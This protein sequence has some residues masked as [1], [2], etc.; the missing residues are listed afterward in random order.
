MFAKRLFAVLLAL[1]I[2]VATAVTVTT[3]TI[4]PTQ[5]GASSCGNASGP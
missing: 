5:A 3:L 1:G 2:L 4:G